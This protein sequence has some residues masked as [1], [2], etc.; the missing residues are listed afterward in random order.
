M[1]D[2]K[3]TEMLLQLGRIGGTNSIYNFLIGEKVYPPT[4]VSD[5][6]EIK[7]KLDFDI[8]FCEDLDGPAPDENIVLG[9]LREIG[10]LVA[11]AYL[12]ELEDYLAET[13]SES[14]LLSASSECETLAELIDDNPALFEMSD[15]LSN[16]AD[17]SHQN[18]KNWV[19]DA[20]K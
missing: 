19:A 14:D 11:S 15:T 20:A 8:G 12:K 2:K 9:Y 13:M 4:V 17:Q 1:I 3:K 5:L 18:W 6:L 7:K 16:R 10:K